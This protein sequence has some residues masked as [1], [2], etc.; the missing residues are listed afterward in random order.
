MNEERMNEL[1]HVAIKTANDLMD[2]RDK[3]RKQVAELQKALCF[4]L[5]RILREEGPVQDRISKDAQ[6][7]RGFFP[8]DPVEGESDAHSLGWI[9][10]KKAEGL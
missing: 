3:L 4:W 6:L 8:F 1:A 2:E 10:I 9:E 5:P 7:L